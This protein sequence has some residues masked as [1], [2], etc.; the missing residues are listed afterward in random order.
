M[1][2]SVK[3]NR[4]AEKRCFFLSRSAGLSYLL[5]LGQQCPVCRDPVEFPGG[6]GAQPLGVALLL[7]LQAAPGWFLWDHIHVLQ[8]SHR[9]KLCCVQNRACAR[10]GQPWEG[11]PRAARCAALSARFIPGSNTLMPSARGKQTMWP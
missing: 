8:T 3:I 9:S 10:A 4:L 11:A 6:T 2:N 1:G 7:A 5:S